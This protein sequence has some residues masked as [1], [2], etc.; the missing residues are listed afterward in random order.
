VKRL[1]ALPTMLQGFSQPFVHYNRAPGLGIQFCARRAGPDANSD[2]INSERRQRLAGGWGL[3]ARSRHQTSA[4]PTILPCGFSPWLT[5]PSSWGKGGR[6]A[7][8]DLVTTC[9]PCRPHCHVVSRQLSCIT[10]PYIELRGVGGT[11]LHA[12]RNGPDAF[13]LVPRGPNSDPKH[14]EL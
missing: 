2:P 11:T 13:G 8:Q 4:L 12:Q 7:K 1:S 10:T 6:L 5:S 9:R 14:P 3:E